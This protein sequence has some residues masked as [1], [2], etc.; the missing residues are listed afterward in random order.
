M[1]DG[2]PQYHLLVLE[3][4]ESHIE[5]IRRGFLDQPQ[6]QISFVET[7][8]EARDIIAAAPPDLI[9]ADWLLP[10]GKGI[11]VLQQ[12]NR[13]TK[14]PLIIMTSYGNEELAVQMIKAGAVDYIVKSEY[15][16]RDLPRIALRALQEWENK[17]RRD[18]AEKA[19]Q[20]SEKKF[21]LIFHVNPVINI[22]TTV[23]D[24]RIYDIN[25]TFETVT[26]YQR[27]EIL[28]KTVKEL[29]LWANPADHD[30][31]MQVLNLTGMYRE[32]QH[33]FRKKDGELLVCIYS[34]VII[35]IG[36][37]NHVLSTLVDV[38]GHES[39]VKALRESESR[40]HEIFELSGEA[41]FLVDAQTLC[42]D[43]ANSEAVPCMGMAEIS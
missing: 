28:G 38:T 41:I 21:S 15:I 13:C 34:S 11:D 30:V 26:G 1:S 27:D 5:L 43:E 39:A 18:E 35:D 12:D 2:S 42:I 29:G 4:D 17:N 37:Q 25:T 9:L 3:D 19:L 32:G 6:F 16:Y 14:I 10:D 20:E 22:I 24:H 8:R 31:V 36:G 33:Y 7:I 40:F 23:P